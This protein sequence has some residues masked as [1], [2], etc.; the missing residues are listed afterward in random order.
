MSIFEEKY[1]TIS[2][3]F[4][5]D[6]LVELGRYTDDGIFSMI[7]VLDVGGMLWEGKEEY[8]SIEDALND[9]EEFLAGWKKEEF[10]DR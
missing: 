8:D 7:R 6:G 5:S 1:P 9:A 2:W 4:S 10:P 3:W